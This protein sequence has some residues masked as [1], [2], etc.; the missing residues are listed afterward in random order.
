MKI[1]YISWQPYCSRSDNTARELG[2]KSYLIYYDIFGSDYRTIVFKYF[3]QALKTLCILI[4]DS[5]DVVF[6]M[7]PPVFACLPVFLYCRV[8]GKKYVVDAHTGAFKDAVWQKVMF[9]QRFFC[10]RAVFTITTNQE[11]AELLTSWKSEYVIVQDVPIKLYQPAE[12]VLPAKINVTLVNT[13]AKDEPLDTFLTAARI[14]SDIQFYVTGKIKDKESFLIKNAPDNVCFTDF[15]SYPD[16]YGLL[17]HSTLIIVLTTRDL[18]MQRGAYE[19]IYLGK[20]VVTSNWSILK[21]NFKTG[22]VFV[23]NT[24]EGIKK[25]IKEA[26]TNISDLE[27]GAEQLRLS[28]LE[29]WN[30]NLEIIRSRLK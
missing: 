16:Y 27:S 5:P 4:K 12:T 2:G 23:E 11:L 24:I 14:L 9:L 26:I 28:K 20:P 7:S 15:L 22:A 19:A 3:F 17:K 6:V 8:M 10:Q 1:V 25:G 29:R 18:T 13:F 30:K 21:E